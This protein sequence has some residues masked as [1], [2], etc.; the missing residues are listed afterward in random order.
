MTND[1]MLVLD[2]CQSADQNWFS[3][4]DCMAVSLKPL[5]QQTTHDL[6]PFLYCTLRGL[7]GILQLLPI[8]T[9]L[10]HTARG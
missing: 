6:E 4:K 8:S 5:S 2:A 3:T 1:R 10:I 9:Q 7:Q